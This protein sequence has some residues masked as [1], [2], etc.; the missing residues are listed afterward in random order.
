[1]S[2][3]CWM[4]YNG[5]RILGHVKASNKKQATNLAKKFHGDGCEVYHAGY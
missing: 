3:S 5:N 1:M 2:L 4:V